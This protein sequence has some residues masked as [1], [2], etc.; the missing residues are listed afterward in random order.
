VRSHFADV[1]VEL[2]GVGGSILLLAFIGD[3]FGEQ[4]GDRRLPLIE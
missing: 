4:G 2:I 3:G 1:I